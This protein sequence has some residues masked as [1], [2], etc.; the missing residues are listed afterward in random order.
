M[1]QYRKQLL[2]A[3]AAFLYKRRRRALD[4]KDQQNTQ[5]N[6]EINYKINFKPSE[7]NSVLQNFINNRHRRSPKPKMGTTTAA[8][9]PQNNLK[10]LR[11]NN[12]E[13]RR[14]NNKGRKKG[15]QTEFEKVCVLSKNIFLLPTKELDAGKS[16]SKKPFSMRRHL[17]R[18]LRQCRNSK[19]GKRPQCHF[20]CWYNCS[21]R[22]WKRLWIES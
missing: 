10:N 3:R 16:Q 22:L 5:N 17:Q 18:T 14:Q 1:D 20:Q 12:N 2:G 11:R 15:M 6:N 7:W 21:S 19:A 13:N 8:R 9:Q 4:R